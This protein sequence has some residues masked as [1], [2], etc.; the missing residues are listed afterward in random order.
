MPISL[1]RGLD[2]VEIAAG[3]D[4]RALLAASSHS[5]VQF[6][7][8]GVTGMIAAFKPAADFSDLAAVIG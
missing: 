7:W 1:M 5:S 3:I 6:C 2:A 4:H 8:N